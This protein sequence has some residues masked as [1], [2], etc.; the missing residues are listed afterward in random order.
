MSVEGFDDPPALGPAARG[1]SGAVAP[2]ASPR[3]PRRFA[4]P[5]RLGIR[6]RLGAPPDRP[7][8]AVAV[9]TPLERCPDPAQDTAPAGPAWRP[10][11]MPR[12]RRRLPVTVG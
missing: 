11:P 9:R 1:D 2:A 12:G 4:E 8:A 3:D 7:E 10:G 6:R 5:D